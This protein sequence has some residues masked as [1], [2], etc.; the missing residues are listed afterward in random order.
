MSTSTR[1]RLRCLLALALLAWPRAAP[2]IVGDTMGLF[3]VEGSVRMIAAGLINPTIGVPADLRP[4]VDPLLPDAG[5][6]V[7]QVLLRL[8]AG[9]WPTA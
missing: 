8:T 6:G 9:G 2:A 4:L 3:G 1:S 7:S 5:D